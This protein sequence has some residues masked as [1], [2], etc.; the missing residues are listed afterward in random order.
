[1]LWRGKKKKKKNDGDEGGESGHREQQKKPKVVVV[2]GEEVLGHYC[3][4]ELSVQ[5]R[6]EWAQ[7]ALGGFCMCE[8]CVWEAALEGQSSDDKSTVK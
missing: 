2:R 4:V 1:M 8:R 3:D 5:D 7:G 6:R